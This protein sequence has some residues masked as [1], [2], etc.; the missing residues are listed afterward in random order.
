MAIVDD[1]STIRAILVELLSHHAFK[2]S[3]VADS[4]H[5]NKIL[6]SD[7]VDLV[8]VDLNLGHEDG[9]DIVRKLTARDDIAVIIMSGD[10]LEE[11]DRSW[12][13][14]WE[15]LTTLPSRSECGSLSH[16]SR[17][18]FA[19]ETSDQLLWTSVHITLQGGL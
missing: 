13:L 10:R 14:N 4:Q 18:P 12:G 8:L 16:A 7:P 1:D 17:Q 2:V 5:S 19:S 15:R 11:A 9:L 6:A 3:A